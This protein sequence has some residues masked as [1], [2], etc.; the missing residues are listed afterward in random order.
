MTSLDLRVRT[1]TLALLAGSII[2]LSGCAQTAPAAP[3]GNGDAG[4]PGSSEEAPAAAG[5]KCEDNTSD[6]EIFA[7]D[8][9]TNPPEYGQVWGDGSELAFDYA[10][11]TPGSTVS[12]QL[13]Y[14]Q[15]D[16]GVIN[17]TGGPFQDP[18]GTRFSS[19]D[20]QFSSA[21]EGYYGIVEV[22]MLSDVDFDG[23]KYTGT[24]TPVANF[25]VTL[26]VSE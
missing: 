17:I 25:C 9:V 18:V 16:G 23:E 10:G 12:Y 26:A 22:T 5:P 3:T 8:G 6:Y 2:V 20:P 4:D 14:V 24:T 11:F 19:V 1:A 7:E 13:Y 21:S 15:D